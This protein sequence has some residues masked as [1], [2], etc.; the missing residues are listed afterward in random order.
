MI[1][2]LVFIDNS[3]PEKEIL[4][5]NINENNVRIVTEVNSLEGIELINIKQIGF[6]WKNY[7]I[8]TVKPS[9]PEFNYPVERQIDTDNNE[10][11]FERK[12]IKEIAEKFDNLEIID[13]I[14]CDLNEDGEWKDAFNEIDNYTTRYSINRTGSATLGGDW[15]LESHGTNILTEYFNGTEFVY[16]HHLAPSDFQEINMDF[17]NNYPNLSISGNKLVLNNDTPI[18]GSL[19]KTLKINATD[20]FNCIDGNGHTITFIN[21]N[22]LIESLFFNNTGN[23]L[24]IKNLIVNGD[25][26][27]SFKG[28][29]YSENLCPAQQVVVKNCGVENLQINDSY[30]AIFGRYAGKES[31]TRAISCYST[32]D[33][34]IYSGGIYGSKAGYNNGEAYAIACYSTGKIS[35]I[36]SGGIYGWYAGDQNGSS[37]AIACY[38]TSHISYNFSGGIYASFTG[39][40]NGSAYAIA[41]YSTGDISK[42]Y[43]GGI[44]GNGAGNNGGTAY[45][46]SCY[47]TGDING[48]NSGGIYGSFAGYKNLEEEVGTAYAIACY[49]TGYISGKSSGGIYGPFAGYGAAYA[50]A[51][52]STGEKDS[53]KSGLGYIFAVAAININAVETFA[54]TN[55]DTNTDGWKKYDSDNIGSGDNENFIDFTAVDEEIFSYNTTKPLKNQLELRFFRSLPW[56]PSHPIEQRPFLLD[57]SICYPYFTRAFYD[58]WFE[59]NNA[60]FINNE[61]SNDITNNDVKMLLSS[62][63]DSIIPPYMPELFIDE[64]IQ[65]PININEIE[66]YDMIYVVGS[67]SIIQVTDLSN[68]LVNGTF[69]NSNIFYLVNKQFPIYSEFNDNSFTKKTDTE[70]PFITNFYCN[71]NYNIAFRNWQEFNKCSPSFATLQNK[72]VD[73]IY[74]SIIDVYTNTGKKYYFKLCCNKI[75]KLINNTCDINVIFKIPKCFEK[76]NS[77]FYIGSEILF[78]Y[79]DLEYGLNRTAVIKEMNGCY[80]I[81]LPVKDN[82]IESLI[83]INEIKIPI[84]KIYCFDNNIFSKQF[85]FNDL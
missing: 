63:N 22:S 68:N 37:Y 52:Y 2:K 59:T 27:N 21:T 44:Y 78:N 29:V 55:T 7:W 51:C 25:A 34:S 72:L 79:N 56:N 54:I 32:G 49:S 58:Y 30:G 70:N 71:N 9:F 66:L 64:I 75:I 65:S 84:N 83:C 73:N 39:Y 19:W 43:C 82:Q 16:N 6:V 5:N 80:I 33:I 38:S 60:V 41:C 50:T 8:G 12:S 85:L 4:I 62:L 40:R 81:E 18:D 36:H 1:T 46:I 3:V 14:T 35:N 57:W 15:I 11:F 24:V 74:L 76:D 48:Q 45:A 28:I 13:L 67:N 61:I 69:N 31:N 47:S 10:L 17:F 23:E 42:T 26:S 77:V 53:N 20:T